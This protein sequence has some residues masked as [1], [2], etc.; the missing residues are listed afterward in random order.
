M[1]PKGW[2]RIWKITSNGSNQVKTKKFVYG[3]NVETMGMIIKRVQSEEDHKNNLS[4]IRSW[5]EKFNISRKKGHPEM[6]PF[7]VEI[8]FG[9]R[10]EFKK[11]ELEEYTKLIKNIITN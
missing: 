4:E 6:I 5:M 1:K 2:K 9:F 11:E 8:E 7:L 10:F 3:L